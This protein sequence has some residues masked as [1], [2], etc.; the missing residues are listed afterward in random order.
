MLATVILLTFAVVQILG[1]AARWFLWY[2]VKHLNDRLLIR[3]SNSKSVPIIQTVIAI[4]YL[5]ALTQVT[6]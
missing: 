6:F 2:Q 4:T 3:S 5:F 1:A